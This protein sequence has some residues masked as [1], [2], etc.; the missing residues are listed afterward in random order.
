MYIIN[1]IRSLS[2]PMY[3]LSSPMCTVC[4][5]GLGPTW[6]RYFCQFHKLENG[7]RGRT[8]QMKYTP[9]GHHGSVSVCE[10]GGM[11]KVWLTKEPEW[12]L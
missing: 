10:G 7:P 3:V 1:P 4:I 12:Y 9:V 8:R 2:P 11:G 6:H 5:V